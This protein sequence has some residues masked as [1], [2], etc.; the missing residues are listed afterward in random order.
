V[1]ASRPAPGFQKGSMTPSPP[2]SSPVSPRSHS[3]EH[4]R[5]P[6]RRPTGAPSAP[7]RPPS[8]PSC[9]CPFDFARWARLHPRFLPMPLFSRLVAARAILASSGELPLRPAMVSVASSLIWPWFAPHRVHRRPCITPVPSVRR[10]VDRRALTDLS[11]EL[12]ATG[13]GAPPW[14]LLFL[15]GSSSLSLPLILC[16][17]IWDQWLSMIY[18]PSRVLLLKNPPVFI[19]LNPPSLAYS[20]NTHSYVENVVS[21]V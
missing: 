6:Q 13:N 16:R 15:V 11:G 14:L 21:L 7:P 8:F 17:L 10:T 12:L 18:T 20:Q 1:G 4:R 5:E 9:L 2:F 3:L 19:Y